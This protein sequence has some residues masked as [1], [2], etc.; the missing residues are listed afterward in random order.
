LF[1]VIEGVGQGANTGLGAVSVS[2]AGDL[3]V[4]AGGSR[5]V[6]M[7]WIDRSGKRGIP[8]SPPLETSAFALSADGR[9]LAVS[10]N[11]SGLTGD[12]WTLAVP[13][14]TPSKFTFGPAPG[15][16]YPVWSP[17]ASE[18]AYATLDNAG[19]SGY[20]L[21][22]RKSDMTGSEETLLK[23]DTIMRLWDWSPDGTYL[24][25]NADSALWQL[26]LEAR[27]GTR[28]PVK[29]TTAPTDEQYGQVSPDGRWL[30]Y[31]A[32]SRGDTQVYVQ[33]MPA[34]GAIWLVS[35]DGGT[36]PRWRRDGKELYYRGTDGRL[37]AVPIVAGQGTSF[38]NGAP[39]ALFGS[40]PTLGNITRFPY[41]PSADGQRFLV[42]MP[43]ESAAK[44]MTVVLNWQPAIRR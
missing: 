14:G 4:W 19:L 11:G 37:M 2:A 22:R 31:A 36:M 26:P 33:P 21:R 17:N 1:P 5:T 20:E 8:A 29:L 18:I 44:P 25:Y 7:T 40:I 13:D 12:V 24:V 10:V 9:R 30:A 39:Q 42:A 28:T 27:E 38:Q 41:Q 6:E 3:I 35:K 15:W 34:T 23:S 43:V 32:G 16:T